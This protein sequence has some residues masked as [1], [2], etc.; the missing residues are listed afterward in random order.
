M[1]ENSLLTRPELSCQHHPKSRVSIVCTELL[2]QS[3]PLLCPTCMNDFDIKNKHLYHEANLRSS[4]EGLN[5]VAAMIDKDRAAMDRLYRQ[6]VAKK[7]NEAIIRWQEDKERHY[8]SIE[9]HI[10]SLKY[11]L[12]EEIKNIYRLFET[13]LVEAKDLVSQSLDVY[14]QTYKDNFE[15]FSKMI[16]PLVQYGRSQKYFANVNNITLKLL[17]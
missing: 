10:N 15:I 9:N 3:N 4:W 2:C 1:F 14:Y 7:E 11:Q 16:D 17:T 6:G 5:E 8:A 12:E 13:A